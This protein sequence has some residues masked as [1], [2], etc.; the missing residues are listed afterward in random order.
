V[1]RAVAAAVGA[2]AGVLAILLV[3]VGQLGKVDRQT[4]VACLVAA[5]ATA[6]VVGWRRL[7]A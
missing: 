4:L 2:F 7:R 1:L 6:A 5:G 3:A